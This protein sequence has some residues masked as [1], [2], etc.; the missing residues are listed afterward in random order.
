M[1]TRPEHL[2][3][4]DA[5]SP[6][7]VG[8][9]PVAAELDDSDAHIHLY[10]SQSFSPAT[11][12]PHEPVTP[13]FRKEMLQPHPTGAAAARRPPSIPLSPRKRMQ[14]K[15]NPLADGMMYLV[16]FVGGMFGTALRYSLWLL[17][18]QP[19]SK[20]GL[21]MA[22]H[23]ATLIANLCACFIFA[24]LVSYMSQA[25]WVRK[26]TR[27]LANGGFGMG[28]C[29]GFSTLSAM[30]VEDITSLHSHSYLGFFLYTLF[31]FVVAFV[32]AWFGTWLGLR[33]A[34]K[35]T[36]MHVRERMETV[37]KP[38]IG[39]RVPTANGVQMTPSAG[40]DPNPS[41]D[42]LPIIGEE[43]HL[44]AEA[45]QHMVE[46]SRNAADRIDGGVR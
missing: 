6:G 11:G 36:G 13:D 29:G 7:E 46:P 26:R 30:M 9:S 1:T 17:W 23:P 18:P 15:F 40:D 19:L 28:M 10:D 35:R 25:V 2:T 37:R 39:V 16:I 24:V 44:D 33:L 20:G 38:A 34:R 12:A 43:E 45:G 5:T 4:A 41:T 42:E 21:L 3:H 8:A 32:I 22:F 14:A 27:Q 31:T